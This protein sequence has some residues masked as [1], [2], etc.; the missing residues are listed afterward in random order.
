[1]VLA[2]SVYAHDPTLGPV[3]YPCDAV[4]GKG[5]DLH[6]PAATSPITFHLRI[7]TA[8]YNISWP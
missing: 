5:A 4:A 6:H 8:P 2:S 3:C 7:S 1:M